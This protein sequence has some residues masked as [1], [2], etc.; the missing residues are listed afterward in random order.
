MMHEMEISPQNSV[1][2]SAEAAGKPQLPPPPSNLEHTEKGSLRSMWELLM[3]LRT[4]LPYLS[5]LVPLLDRGLS[6]IAPDL[7]EV[8]KGIAEVQSGSRDLGAQARNQALRLEQ[9]E[10]QLTRLSDATE[11][12]RRQGRD[13]ADALHSLTGW[14][15]GLAILSGLALV[16]LIFLTVAAALQL[17]HLGR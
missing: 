1:L 3:Q 17:T 9:I 6:K 7:S 13:L 2:E 11:Q 16:L 12:N 8:R 5:S 15:R 14:V 10:A 4:L